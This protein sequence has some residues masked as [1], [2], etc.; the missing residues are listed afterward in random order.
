MNP[1]VDFGPKRPVP[2]PPEEADVAAGVA[3]LPRVP[4]LSPAEGLLV[5]KKNQKRV[6]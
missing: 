6:Y 1:A 5:T 3:V 2:K 4:K